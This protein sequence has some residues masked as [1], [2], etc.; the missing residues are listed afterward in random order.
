MKI[1]FGE[2]KQAYENLN[3]LISDRFETD[4]QEKLNQF[5]S[6]TCESCVHY[7]DCGKREREPKEEE[8]EAKENQP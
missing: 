8:I 5:F 1:S 6:Q 7:A 2:A 4:A 3:E